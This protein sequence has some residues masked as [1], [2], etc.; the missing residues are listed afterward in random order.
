MLNRLN[1]RIR[2]LRCFRI[3]VKG[4]RCASMRLCEVSKWK[5]ESYTS[6]QACFQTPNRTCSA[7]SYVI[8]M[9]F[10]RLRLDRHHRRRRRDNIIMAVITI[11]RT[12][13]KCEYTFAVMWRDLHTAALAAGCDV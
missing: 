5:K 12:Q 3:V 7:P 11:G 8:Y 10:Q 6:G 13:I 2:W 9:F 4:I 1:H